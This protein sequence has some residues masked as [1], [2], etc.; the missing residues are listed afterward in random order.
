M[1]LHIEAVSST[2]LQLLHELMEEKLLTAFSLA[3][4]TALALRFGHRE[5]V[6]IDLFTHI[7]FDARILSEK[8][9]STYDVKEAETAENTVRGFIEGIKVDFIAHRYPLLGTIE[10][11]DGIRIVSIEDLAAMKLNAIANRGCKKDFWDYAELLHLFSRDEMLGLYARKYKNDSI[12]NV[13]KS[14]AWFDDA[15]EEP[16]PRDLRKQSWA[17]IKQ[18]VRQSNR[19]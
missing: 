17:D 10:K 12:W 18:T 15:E 16:D 3:G 9:K 8:L 6:D 7:P 11:H 13:E 14:L 5:S 4:G 1:T 19:L 2:L